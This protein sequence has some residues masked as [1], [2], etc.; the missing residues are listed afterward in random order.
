MKRILNGFGKESL[1]ET[2]KQEDTAKEV[3]N[4]TEEE[5]DKT[6]VMSGPLS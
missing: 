5:R 4:K 6:V 2:S 1:D 3:V